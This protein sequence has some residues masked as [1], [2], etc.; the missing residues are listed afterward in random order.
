MRLCIRVSSVGSWEDE[1]SKYIPATAL[2]KM[3]VYAEP[4]PVKTSAQEAAE[5]AAKKE[6]DL[7]NE[8]ESLY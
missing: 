2:P 4:T 5:V 6:K 3:P 8:P 1:E 7:L